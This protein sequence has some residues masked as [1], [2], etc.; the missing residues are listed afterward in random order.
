[1]SLAVVHSRATLGIEAPLITVEAHLSKGM[2]GFH[3]VGLP[4]MAV[5][6]SRERVRSAFINSG[7]E[8]PFTYHL[9]INLAP[10]DLPKSGGR[11]DL[12]I[13]V[14]IL[15]ASGQLDADK[16]GGYEF[17]GEL[18]LSGEI[19]GVT[20]LLPGIIACRQAR[21]TC[22]APAANSGEA[23][24]VKGAEVKLAGHLLDV[25]A[26]L[27]GETALLSPIR[28][29]REPPAEEDDL[30]EVSG[31]HAARRAL[32]VAAAG[33]HNLLMHGPPGSGKTMLASRMPGILPPLDDDEALEVAAI[34]SIASRRLEVSHWARP[35]FRAPHHTSS[36]VALVGGGSTPHAGEIS[37]A[38]RGVL[39]LDEL[40]EFS[41]RVLEVLRE[42]LESGAIQI[43]R[44]RY[45][46]RLPARFQLVAAMNPCPCGYHGDPQGGCRCPEERVLAYRQRISGPLLDRIDLHVEVP[47]LSEAERRDLLRR[48]EGSA[49]A[50]SAALR[51]RVRECRWRQLERAGKLNAHLR[52]AELGR[53]CRLT[54]ADAR[55]LEEAVGRLRLSVRACHRVLKIA[56][57]IADLEESETIRRRHLLE[58]V[59]YR[60]LDRV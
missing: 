3:I 48:K 59:N 4:E 47:R 18:A 44:A 46:V 10:A 30:R 16:L 6:E 41:P 13:A 49:D 40:P 43:S 1:M 8:F 21:R 57:T 28:E 23:G 50:A 37:L 15:A 5:K 52:P 55:L 56:R 32:L 11:F 14:G 12:A 35:P 7:L 22:L 9:L 60:K 25:C 58:A 26:F 33:A 54:K 29:I 2:P 17:L 24:L 42:P 20:G 38:H 27:K 19:R 31:Q 45:Q 51:E 34:R 36:A 39:F 53:D